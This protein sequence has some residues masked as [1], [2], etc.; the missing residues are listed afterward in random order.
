MT[1]SRARNQSEA[2]DP[3]R[4]AADA[5]RQVANLIKAARAARLTFLAY[6]LS[7]AM[8]EARSLSKATDAQPKREIGD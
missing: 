3:S 4:V 7:L 6:L 5:V 1:P 2:G 8:A